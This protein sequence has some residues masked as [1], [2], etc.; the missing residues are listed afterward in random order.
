MKKNTLA[1]LFLATLVLSATPVL[2]QHCIEAAWS[3]EVLTFYGSSATVAEKLSK[4]QSNLLDRR[5][6]L[7][8]SE[9]QGKTE[10]AFFERKDGE[11]VLLS[12]WATTS[13]INLAATLNE[14]ILANAG[15]SCVGELTKAALKALGANPDEGKV[16]TAPRTAL[17]A[18]THATFQQTP[19]DYVRVTVL[20][21]C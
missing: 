2:A 17:A 4:V 19:D 13:K 20:F 6:Y 16:I 9:T 18:Y 15:V 3:P 8:V 14:R 12:H 10:V 11:N 5:V 1:I 7:I 21:G